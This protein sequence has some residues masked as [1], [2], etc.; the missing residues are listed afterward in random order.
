MKI[1]VC[2]ALMTVGIVQTESQPSNCAPRERLATAIQYARV[3]NTA[4]ANNPSANG[5][6]PLSELGIPSPPDGYQVQLTTDRTTYA[7]S[8]KDNADA[9]HGVVFS[10]QAGVIYTGAP[11]Q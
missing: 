11:L 5:Y 7:F 8:I 2:F 1:V 6:R 10:D 4:E 9:C 3:I